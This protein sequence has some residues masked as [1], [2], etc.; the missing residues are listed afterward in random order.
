MED[1]VNSGPYIHVF[2]LIALG[3]LWYPKQGISIIVYGNR[4][5]DR[6]DD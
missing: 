5:R 1:P 6:T 2:P 3:V 4:F